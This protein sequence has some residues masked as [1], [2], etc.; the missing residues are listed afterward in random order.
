MSHYHESACEE[1][2]FNCMNSRRQSSKEK[3]GQVEKD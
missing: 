3:K 1:V 2:L